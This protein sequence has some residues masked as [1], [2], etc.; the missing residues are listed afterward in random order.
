MN[1]T[2]TA[3]PSLRN[4][5][6]AFQPSVLKHTIVPLSMPESRAGASTN[7]DLSNF[8]AS[9]TQTFTD[10]KT[11]A[12]ATALF[13]RNSA[14]ADGKANAVFT[15]GTNVPIADTNVSL[16]TTSIAVG[17]GRRYN[18]NAEGKAIIKGL[19]FYVAPQ[20]PFKFDFTGS[21]VLDT[22]SKRANAFA[23]GRTHLVV[24][25][26]DVQGTSTAIDR[27]LIGGKKSNSGTQLNFNIGNGF[28]LNTTTK[29]LSLTSNEI[30]FNGTYSRTFDAATKIAVVATQKTSV[31]ANRSGR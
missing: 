2:L 24:Y 9:P 5:S 12:N 10:T 25:A 7:L 19:D 14:F 31:K 8:S 16:N 4:P 18:A 27:L 11:Q 1:Q 13:K 26:T 23:A 17:L 6:Q 29:P 28:T 20:E 15:G 3:S 22:Q 21:M 30:S